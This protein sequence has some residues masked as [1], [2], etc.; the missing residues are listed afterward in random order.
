MFSNIYKNN[1]YNKTIKNKESD[2]KV[3]ASVKRLSIGEARRLLSMFK[4]SDIQENGK[5]LNKW[6]LI[7][8]IIQTYKDNRDFE[9]EAPEESF[10]LMPENN[11]MSL[12]SRQV[13]LFLY[14]TVKK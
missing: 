14:A 11:P 12:A 2:R 3:E 1:N 8:K 13:I 4:V 10:E 7:E 5:R 6:G 9:L